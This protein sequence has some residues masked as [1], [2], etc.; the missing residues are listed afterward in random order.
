MGWVLRK[1]VDDINQSGLKDL[2]NRAYSIRRPIAKVNSLPDNVEFPKN[3][4]ICECD[5]SFLIVFV[6][7]LGACRLKQMTAE[8]ATSPSCREK[9]GPHDRS[10]A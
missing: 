5:I 4:T 8:L 7:R 10:Q 3:P 1:A 6:A 2:I 9:Q